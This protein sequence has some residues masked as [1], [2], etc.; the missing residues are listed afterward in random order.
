[1]NSFLVFNYHSLPFNNIEEAKSHIPDFIKIAVKSQA[2]GLSV[3]LINE[4]LDQSWYRLELAP[5]YFW[6]DWFQ[7]FRDSAEYI[8]L[9]RGYRSIA[10]RQPFFGEADYR[11]GADLF[12]VS[13]NDK[14]ESLSALCAAAWFESPLTSFPTRNPWNETPINVC[15]RSMNDTGE[16]K[17]NNAK[18][19]NLYSVDVFEALKQFYSERKLSLIT[20]GKDLL[21]QFNQLYPHIGLCG[22]SIEQLNNWSYSS[23]ILE[24]VKETFAALNSFVEK[25]QNDEYS[26]YSHVNLRNSGLNHQ[27]SGESQTVYNDQSLRREREFFLPTGK[28]EYFEKHIK[29]SQGLRIHFFPD[30]QTKTIYVGYIGRHLR[31]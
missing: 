23:T 18:L 30:V 31:L 6:Q 15:I 1:L 20:S 12:E 24:Q 7:E 27:V 10:T 25:W 13:L 22:K 19:N 4:N 17:I 16:I 26:D 11:E 14:S 28:K 29:I 5:G 8:E 3:I 21:R 9:I 2:I